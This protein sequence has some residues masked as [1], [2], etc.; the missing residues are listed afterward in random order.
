MSVWLSRKK[1]VAAEVP[2]EVG[3]FDQPGV[4]DFVRAKVV[5]AAVAGD[6]EARDEVFVFDGFHGDGD[7]FGAKADEHAAHGYS[8][9]CLMV[10][11]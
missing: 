8:G 5:F 9:I 6:E 10:F 2:Y 1:V 3:A 11:A 7:V 4:P